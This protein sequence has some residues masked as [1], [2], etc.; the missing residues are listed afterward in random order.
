MPL[1]I[2]NENF[3]CGGFGAFCNQQGN[4]GFSALSSNAGGSQQGIGGFSAFS[5]GC[6]VGDKEG[7]GCGWFMVARQWW[8]SEKKENE[9]T[10]HGRAVLN[11]SKVRF[12]FSCGPAIG[13]RLVWLPRSNGLTFRPSSSFGI[14]NNYPVKLLELVNYMINLKDLSRN[15]SDDKLRIQAL[16]R[17]EEPVTAKIISRRL[18]RKG[19]E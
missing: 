15:V 9:R 18:K 5:G 12:P 11:D 13:H 14:D 10:A 2:C 3:P 17:C 8:P 6:F 4:G 7:D 19:R 1:R 16:R